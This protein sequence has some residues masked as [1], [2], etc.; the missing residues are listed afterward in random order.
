MKKKSIV[1]S[2]VSIENLKTKKYNI[3]SVKHQ[4]FLLFVAN[5]AVMTKKLLTK[6][7][8]EENIGGF[9]NINKTTIILLKK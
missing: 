7:M 3:F 9:K 1:L 2:V 5:V 4:F 8:V 6:N